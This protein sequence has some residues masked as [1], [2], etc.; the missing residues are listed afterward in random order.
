MNTKF[1]K[2]SILGKPPSSSQSK[3]VSI[4]LFPKS[5]VFPK[6]GE[7]NALSKPVTSNSTPSTRE[8]TIMK[9][10]KVIA[11]G[12]FKTS[13]EDNVLPNKYRASIKTTPI[14]ISQP[15]VISQENVNPNLYGLSS[16]GVKSTTKTKRPPPRS[17]KKND[18]VPSASTSS[19]LKNK[20]VKV[21]EHHR[22]LLL[23]KNKKHM[24]SECNNVKLAIQIASSEVVCVMCKQCLIKANHDVCVL[25]YVND[26]NSCGKKQ[27]ANVS[28]IANEKKQ[29]PKVRKPKTVGSKERLASPKPSKP[30]TCLRWSP[31]RRMF[32][33]KGKIIISSKSECQSD[34]FVSDNACISNLQE[35]IRKQFPFSTFSMTGC[36]NLFMVHRLGVLKAHDRNY[37]TSNKLRLEV[38]GNIFLWK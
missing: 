20:D 21:E 8:S 24:S 3:L 4:T 14:T 32:K 29:K 38:I 1:T 30:R 5:I 13:R 11:P 28:T 12:M 31:T 7:S 37:Q 33:L 19:F 27:K 22:N 25:N 26:I 6:V 36:L 35:P 16:I 9:N 10:D 18:R 34:C 15:Y 17:N 23:S 2:Q